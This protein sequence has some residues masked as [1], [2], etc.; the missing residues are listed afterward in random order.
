[1]KFIQLDFIFQSWNKS[2]KFW[3]DSQNCNKNTQIKSLKSTS[4]QKIVFFLY[5]VGDNSI[6]FIESHWFLY[7]LIKK[8]SNI[9]TN[10]KE[11]VLKIVSNNPLNLSFIT[12]LVWV[13]LPCLPK[14][15]DHLQKYQLPSTFHQSS[16]RSITCCCPRH[17]TNRPPIPRLVTS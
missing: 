13:K 4:E 6:L 1:M 12:C 5:L 2:A 15:Q 11:V 9:S 3:L 17:N 8:F 7:G 10:H 14:R 16:C